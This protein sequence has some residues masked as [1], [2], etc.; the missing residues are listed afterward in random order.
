MAKSKLRSSVGEESPG[1]AL[2]GARIHN[3]TFI[4]GLRTVKV[5]VAEP[6][7]RGVLRQ[8]PLGAAVQDLV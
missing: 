4:D 3:L 5:H 7:G 2:L 8:S 6:D 1:Q